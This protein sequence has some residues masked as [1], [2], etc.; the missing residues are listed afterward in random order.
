MSE[1]PTPIH[2]RLARLAEADDLFKQGVDADNAGDWSGYGPVEC[3]GEAVQALDRAAVMY[4]DLGLG[5]KAKETWARVAECL[6]KI[7]AEHLL[8]AKHRDELRDSVDVL[9]EM[10]CDE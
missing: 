5:L 2:E 9:W 6:R 10:N 8:W 3:W 4:R 1:S 7:A